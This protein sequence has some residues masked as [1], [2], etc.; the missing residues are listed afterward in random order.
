MSD[1]AFTADKIKA[2]GYRAV[3]QR[4][5]SGHAS[6]IARFAREEACSI[7]RRHDLDPAIHPTLRDTL[8]DLLHRGCQDAADEQRAFM[9]TLLDQ[10]DETLEL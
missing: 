3:Q 7:L 2:I 10:F 9:G 4:R 8:S 6:S 1:L 5:I